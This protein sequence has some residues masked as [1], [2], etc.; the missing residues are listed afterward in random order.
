MAWNADNTI[1]WQRDPT[2][3]KNTV[4][5]PLRAWGMSIR[6]NMGGLVILRLEYTKPLSRGDFH[7]YWTLSIGPT[8]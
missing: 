2:D 3:N 4:R 6:A 5:Q 1:K 7:P 8:F